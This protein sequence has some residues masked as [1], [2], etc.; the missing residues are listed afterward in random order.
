MYSQECELCFQDC[1]LRKSATSSKV[2]GCK[3]KKKSLAAESLSKKGQAAETSF[4]NSSNVCDKVVSKP[5]Q[6][7]I[8]LN[9]CI[10]VNDRLDKS[11]EPKSSKTKRRKPTPQP[12][13]TTA[14]TTTAHHS[15]RTNTVGKLCSVDE[16]M[17]LPVIEMKIEL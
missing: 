4:D 5:P 7:N 15:S 3:G 12:A 16:G 14:T 6:S 17:F 13:L 10:D 9:L 11:S 2:A 1:K 8:D